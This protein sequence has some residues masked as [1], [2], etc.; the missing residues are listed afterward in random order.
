MENF[1]IT[2]KLHQLQSI[3]VDLVEMGYEYGYDKNCRYLGNDTEHVLVKSLGLGNKLFLVA[4]GNLNPKYTNS[5]QFSLP[6][7]YAKALDFCLKQ[8]QI[9]N[10]PEFKKGQWLYF[11]YENDSPVIGRLHEIRGKDTVILKETYG[12]DEVMAY[13]INYCRVAQ[14]HEIINHLRQ[15]LERRGFKSGVKYHPLKS[16]NNPYVNTSLQIPYE[17]DDISFGCYPDNC[18]Y[19]CYKPIRIQTHNILTTEAHI[20]HIDYTKSHLV[21]CDGFF[22]EVCKETKLPFGDSECEFEFELKEIYVY[23]KDDDYHEVSFDEIIQAYDRLFNTKINTFL[24]TFP[25]SCQ[26]QIGCLRGS[27]GEFIDIYKLI[28]SNTQ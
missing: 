11:Q 26:I 27:V 22:A 23:T 19:I 3:A 8:I 21:Y 18:L 1:L 9:Y 4:L 20:S 6:T 28:K 12:S 13:N 7:D 2:G 10:T 16:K 17:C 5:K 14:P 25:F 24:V 15:E